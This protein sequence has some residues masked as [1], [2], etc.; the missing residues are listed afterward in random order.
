MTVEEQHQQRTT[1]GAEWAQIAAS[2]LN[3]WYDK[4]PETT[5]KEIFNGQPTDRN[6]NQRVRS[7][8]RICQATEPNHNK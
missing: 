1:I 7:T 8:T 2:A 3:L 4:T 5:L 6:P